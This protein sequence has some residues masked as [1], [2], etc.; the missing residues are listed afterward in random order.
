[1]YTHKNKFSNSYWI[2]INRSLIKAAEDEETE[3]EENRLVSGDMLSAGRRR[4]M[5]SLWASL[6]FGPLSACIWRRLWAGVR[7]ISG[8][9][10]DCE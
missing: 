6:A 8:T 1:M 7:L 3:K 10:E 5:P 2:H 9:L 4:V